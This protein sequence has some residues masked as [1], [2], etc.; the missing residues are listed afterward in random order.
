MELALA[1]HCSLL[2]W[3]QLHDPLFVFMSV[4]CPLIMVSPSPLVSSVSTGR[5]WAQMPVRMI[6]VMLPP[7]VV[8]CGLQKDLEGDG[9]DML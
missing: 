9:R 2:F 1:A 7:L 6:S 4:C 8:D 5:E 3:Y